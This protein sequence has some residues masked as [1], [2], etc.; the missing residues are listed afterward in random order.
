MATKFKL[1]VEPT[2]KAKVSIPVPGGK[3]E[4]VEFT[5]NY[6]TRDDYIAL[7]SA[8]P[9]PSDKELIMR[10]VSGWELSDEF[11]DDNVDQ[12]LQAYQKAAGAIVSKFVEELGP[13]RLGN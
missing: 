5:F 1:A 10:I 7:F 12:L 8:S 9:A 11:N 2:F 4:P 3:A 13:A 6:F